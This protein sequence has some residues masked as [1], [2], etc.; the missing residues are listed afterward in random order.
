MAEIFPPIP[1]ED[2]HSGPIVVNN[3]DGSYEVWDPAQP[4]PL[5]NYTKAAEEAHAHTI[6]GEIIS[7]RTE[8]NATQPIKPRAPQPT[9]IS[10]PRPERDFRAFP[11]ATTTVEAPTRTVPKPQ[12]SPIGRELPN[13]EEDAR[14]NRLAAT[15]LLTGLGVI[16]A[17][18]ALV[19]AHN[20]NA[21]DRPPAA[22]DKQLTPTPSTD[23]NKNMLVLPVPT[24]TPSDALVLPGGVGSS[25]LPTSLPT[26]EKLSPVS[27][28]ATSKAK[29]F[30]LT[31][32]TPAATRPAEQSNQTGNAATSPAS[33]P[34]ENNTT[35]PV[36]TPTPAATES[37]PNTPA[38]TETLEPSAD[39]IAAWKGDVSP[40]ARQQAGEF[41]SDPNIDTIIANTGLSVD[42]IHN[43]QSNWAQ[44]YPFDSLGEP[45][46]LENSLDQSSSPAW[47]ATNYADT[48]LQRAA[49]TGDTDYVGLAW[50]D[51]QVVA[52]L[53]NQLQGGNAPSFPS[54]NSSSLARVVEKNVNGEKVVLVATVSYYPVNNGHNEQRNQLSVAIPVS[55]GKS[56]LVRLAE[57]TVTPANNS[58][59][60]DSPNVTPTLSPTPTSH[61]HGHKGGI[62]GFLFDR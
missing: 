44:I 9:I 20:H 6:Q 53:T 23:G 14:S 61:N 59:N 47:A 2:K 25:A 37:L 16:F 3:P 49:S 1:G 52:D 13:S 11:T 34:A 50:A 54:A 58:A 39:T 18:G 10:V 33:S 8:P 60:N 51:S 12:I 40:A 46:T 26:L 7:E 22:A 32:P 17:G 31:T 45:S 24:E 27:P 28:K 43:Y 21:T 5:P 15:A 30:P 35:T 55:S 36:T 4:Q 62:L 48:L 19:V 56:V 42:K 38:A 29:H 57:Q 41:A